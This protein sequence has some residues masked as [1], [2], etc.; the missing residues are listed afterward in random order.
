LD[1][2]ARG[3]APKPIPTSE[4]PSRESERI[5]SGTTAAV[6]FVGDS[7]HVLLERR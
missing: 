5:W 4:T 3:P 6:Y 2:R 1:A 7:T